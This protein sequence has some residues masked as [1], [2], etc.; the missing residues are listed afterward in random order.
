MQCDLVRG[1]FREEFHAYP[2]WERWCIIAQCGNKA[3]IHFY[4]FEDDWNKAQETAKRIR[5]CAT[6]SPENKSGVWFPIVDARPHNGDR[7]KR[8][9]TY[10]MLSDFTYLNHS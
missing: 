8:R 6:F 5:A 1:T 4:D 9:K 7:R 3:Y 10:K 2:Y